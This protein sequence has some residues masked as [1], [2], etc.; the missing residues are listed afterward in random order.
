MRFSDDRMGALAF[1]EK[2]FTATMECLA[3]NHCERY[4][5]ALNPS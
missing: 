5:K 3:F 1:I 2:H 4:P